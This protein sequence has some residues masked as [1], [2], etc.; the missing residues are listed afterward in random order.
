VAGLRRDR[1]Y[2]GRCRCQRSFSSSRC[3]ASFSLVSKW[4]PKVSTSGFQCG[5]SQTVPL[6]RSPSNTLAI[7]ATISVC[8]ICLSAAPSWS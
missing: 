7:W 2:F 5:A 3:H 6:V 8:P 1:L 4:P